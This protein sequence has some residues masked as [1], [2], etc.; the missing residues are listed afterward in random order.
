MRG[1]VKSGATLSSTPKGEG[2]M[3]TEA[4]EGFGAMYLSMVERGEGQRVRVCYGV[5][6]TATLD[7]LPREH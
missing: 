3:R 1:L 4:S 2:K 6:D 5:G 7:P